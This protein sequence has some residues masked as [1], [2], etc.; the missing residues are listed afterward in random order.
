MIPSASQHSYE[1]RR[2]VLIALALIA[3]AALVY[4]LTVQIGQGAKA[5][6]N[7]G[8]DGL[9]VMLA[10][11]EFR[12]DARTEYAFV[13]LAVVYGGLSVADF[14]TGIALSNFGPPITLAMLILIGLVYMATRDNLASWPV[15]LFSGLVSVYTLLAVFMVDMTSNEVLGFI[16]MG[17]PGQAIVMAIVHRVIVKL[18][19]TLEA[20][21]TQA[22]IQRALAQ[23]SEALLSRGADQPLKTALAAL[24]DATDATYAYIDV[25]RDG[26]DGAHWEVVADARVEGYT[27]HPPAQGDY[28][29][30][31]DAEALL[32][33]GEPA[34]LTVSE[35]T[36]PLRSQYEEAE[37]KAE[38]M[39]PIQIGE[40]WV[41]TIGYTDNLREGTWS[42]A[43][44]DGLM[45]A[46]DMVGAYWQREA[47]REGLMELA[48]A[49]DRFI[50]AVSHELRTPLSAVMGFAGELARNADQYTAG[51]LAEMAEFV[52]SQS[53]ELSELVND[54]LTAERA[55]SGNLTITPGDVKLLEEC[56]RAVDSILEASQIEVSGAEVAAHADGLRTR[57]ILR[58]LITNA[59]RYG[60]N[61]IEIEVAAEGPVARV[62]V[63]DNGAGVKG[64]DGER[65]FDA[66]YRA[67]EAEAKPDSVGLGLSVARQLARLMKGDLVY[68][69]RGG[70][71]E[72]ELTLPLGE[73]PAMME[74]AIG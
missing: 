14:M 45:R 73:I 55:A 19:E 26:S 64:M 49:K 40:R 16:I 5:Y 58:N 30:M 35:L 61:T 22:R 46:A 48:Q 62:T 6:F 65:I 4:E 50:A 37:V 68:R 39:A 32:R 56:Q 11:H 9:L 20:Q 66:Y 34:M 1:A 25:N 43:E 57:Q 7:A 13:F 31:K 27:G 12:H 53:L 15:Y 67:G 47:A 33:A 10:L 41:G 29:G 51:E 17:I 52:Y 36:G 42:Q 69:R 2:A 44:V 8:I 71:T 63:R 24:L 3:A 60:G 59:V 18:H 70:W 74:S 54:L 21:A 28:R 23:S 72:F 38:L